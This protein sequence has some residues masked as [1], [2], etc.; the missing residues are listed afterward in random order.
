MKTL[1]IQQITSFRVARFLYAGLLVFTLSIGNSVF[2]QP[3]TGV[4]K[5]TAQSPDRSAMMSKRMF[6]AIEK[7]TGKPL[8]AAQKQK[9]QAAIK[10]RAAANKAANDKFMSQVSAITGI[11]A[12]ELRSLGRGGGRGPENRR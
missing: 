10:A 7:K 1:Q 2:A 5:S 8:T 6:A 11:K 9:L 3:R 12:N 4:N